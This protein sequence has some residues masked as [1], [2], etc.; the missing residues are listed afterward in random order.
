MSVTVTTS[1]GS[2][3]LDF[4]RVVE[5]RQDRQYGIRVDQGKSILVGDGGVVPSALVVEFDFAEGT[6]ED[7]GGLAQNVIDECKVATV[8]ATA[9]G[10]RAV[11]GIMSHTLTSSGPVVTLRVEFAPTG[12]AYT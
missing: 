1:A 2:R 9:R 3:T 11:D 8:V 4:A 7:T 6:N 12:G 10:D 5:D